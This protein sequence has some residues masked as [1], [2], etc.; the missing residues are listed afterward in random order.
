MLKN[1]FDKY[2]VKALSYMAWGL[3]CSLI[4]GLIVGQIEIGRASC[5][6][7]V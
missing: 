2:V 7:R 4:I 5:R 6:E 1:L 3:F